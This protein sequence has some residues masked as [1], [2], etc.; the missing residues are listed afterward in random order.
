MQPNSAPHNVSAVGDFHLD[1][2]NFSG[3]F[4]LLLS[5][6]AKHKLDVTEV[7][8]AHV[9]DEFIA[10]LRHVRES[11]TGDELVAHNPQKNLGLASE[12]LV[13]AATLLD[14]KAARL[15]PAHEQDDEEAIALLEARDVL[16][17]KLLQYRAY[18]QLAQVF[19]E[20]LHAQQQ[21][22]PRSV[23][24]EPQFASA[25][26]A[27]VWTLSPQRLHQLAER[28]LTEQA[29][30]PPKPAVRVDHLHG[31]AVTLDTETPHILRV[32][33][34]SERGS[35]TFHE[36]IG[37]VTDR[38]VI[39]VRFLAL[40]E[41]FRTGIITLSQDSRDSHL[42]VSLLGKQVPPHDQQPLKASLGASNG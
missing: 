21:F 8:L 31:S 20:R 5:L 13:V 17:A 25:L 42:V 33:N 24:L 22:V 32:L 12:F 30:E 34:T 10:Y 36:L 29:S 18:R 3:P 35:A 23:A 28:A 15:L 26:P 27:L 19:D 37:D 6:I 7:A 38:L 39:V 14:L 11:V 4:D 16:F 9:T 2:D 1:L 40:L 41:L